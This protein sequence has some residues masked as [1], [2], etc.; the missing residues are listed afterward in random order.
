MTGAAP[1]APGAAVRRPGSRRRAGRAALAAAS[2]AALAGAAPERRWV[3]VRDPE[4]SAWQCVEL[5][6]GRAR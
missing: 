5:V 4:G 1:G 6:G 3:T 2:A